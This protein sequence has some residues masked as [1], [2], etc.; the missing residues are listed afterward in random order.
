MT[1]C[2]PVQSGLEQRR[3]GKEASGNLRIC[4]LMID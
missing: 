3:N 2:A 1:D 4:R